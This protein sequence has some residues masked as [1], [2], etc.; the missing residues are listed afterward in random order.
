[1]L[2]I[3]RRFP[4]LESAPSF[5]FF[6]A[7][8]PPLCVCACVFVYTSLLAVLAFLLNLLPAFD[9]IGRL[10]DEGITPNLFHYNSMFMA[11]ERG[12][13]WRE[14]ADL[15]RKM[16]QAGAKPNALTYQPLIGVMDRCQ[17]RDM[18]RTAVCA[19][20]CVCED[21]VWF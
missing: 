15:F 20:V 18:V 16:R 14:A 1:M 2:V 8:V 4:Q 10:Q 17:K 9:P 3:A 5:L 11:L 7:R 13:R 21:G 12:E 19:C 6:G